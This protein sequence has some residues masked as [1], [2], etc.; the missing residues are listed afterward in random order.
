MMGWVDAFLILLLAVFYISLITA[1]IWFLRSRKGEHEFKIATCGLI[2]GSGIWA[3]QTDFHYWPF[4]LVG[5]VG[6][7]YAIWQVDMIN[8]PICKMVSFIAA[9]VETLCRIGV[10][11]AGIFFR[12]LR[13][14]FPS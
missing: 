10:A 2:F 12:S 3:T 13:N 5:L 11:L 4:V 6:L 7:A 8:Q 9:C 1:L 14:K